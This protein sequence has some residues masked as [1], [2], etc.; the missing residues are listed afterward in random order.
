MPAAARGYLPP[1]FVGVSP[2]NLGTAKDFRLMQE[3][4]VRSVRLPLYWSQV[5][6]QNPAFSERH[7]DAFDHEVRLAAEQGME[8][9][10]F[11][12]GS[13]KWVAPLGIDLPVQN[14]WQRRAWASFIRAAVDRYGTNGSFW[15]EEGELPALHLLDERVPL[16]GL[17]PVFVAVDDVVDA[18]HRHRL[19]LA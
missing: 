2:Q 3:A 8:V 18:D 10:P 14:A 15:R 12:T 19:A 1:G 5:E 6:P 4:G 16:A 7:G 13:P 9:F 17:H 11:I